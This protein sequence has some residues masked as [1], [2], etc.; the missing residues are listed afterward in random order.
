MKKSL[1]ILFISQVMIA[2]GY[3]DNAPATPPTGRT[4]DAYYG[5]ISADHTSNG[6]S[7]SMLAW[8]L[9]LAAVITAVSL[10]VPA[11]PAPSP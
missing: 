6:I 7:V 11:D 4:Y 9:G 8:G 2:R 3:C 5:N 10:L 1:L